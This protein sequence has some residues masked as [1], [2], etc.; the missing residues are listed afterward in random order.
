MGVGWR[1][2][3]AKS[4]RAAPRPRRLLNF[5]S[6][7]DE[8]TF[9]LNRLFLRVGG[10]ASITVALLLGVAGVASGPPAFFGFAAA[11][12]A[13]GAI[14]LA[15]ARMARPPIYPVVVPSFAVA[16]GL[17]A[18]GQLPVAIA[19]C[20]ASTALGC[21]VALLDRRAIPLALVGVLTVA[22]VLVLGQEDAWLL[23]SA[24]FAIAL[25]GLAAMCVVHFAVRDRYSRVPRLLHA[26]VEHT[27]DAIILVDRS[28]TIR[29][30]AG[31]A[32]QMFGYRPDEVLGRPLDLLIP[33]QSR[34]AHRVHLASFADGEATSHSMS[35]RLPVHGR[36]HTGAEIPIEVSISK[37]PVDGELYL[38]AIIR[39]I[40]ERRVA[41]ERVQKL[42]DSRLRL[43]A[44]VSHELRTPLT[45]VVGF[46]ELLSSGTALDESERTEALATISREAGDAAA[47]LEDLLVGSRLELGNMFVA[48]VPVDM[49]AQ[50]RQVVEGFA[51]TARP[52]EV[53]PGARPLVTGDPGRTRQVIRNLI[54]NALK[55]GGST[56]GVSVEESGNEG[57]IRV[58]D[59]GAGPSP[60]IVDLMFDAFVSG[61]VPDGKP[62]SFGLGLSI[63]RSLARAMGGD[64]RYDRVG[65]NTRFSLYLP[66]AD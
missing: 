65:G 19:A 38:S 36:H 53:I 9:Y 15:V 18:V 23:R 13:N 34:E 29:V 22:G 33:V 5:L 66:L 28:Q 8:V 26:L 62:G 11:A 17:V 24:G 64:V 40:S 59:D 35:E 39:D 52:I 12:A 25:V 4:R 55:H 21:T 49:A 37:V 45:A 50:V 56:V 10:G 16:A 54:A 57:V 48:G 51:V 60:D 3:G 41:A 46:A 31:T 58:T 30:F 42:A 61:H 32:P 14:A 27:G 44:S 47:T 6:A 7:P 20:I 43:I 2:W 63:S 1:V